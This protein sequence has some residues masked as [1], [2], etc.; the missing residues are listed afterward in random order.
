M[1]TT[2]NRAPL[3]TRVDGFTFSWGA[4]FAGVFTVLSIQVVLSL[5]GAAIGL[6]TV[7]PITQHSPLSGMTFFGA[8]WWVVSG[9]I[10]LSIGSFVAGHLPE[11]DFE[12]E[13]ETVGLVTWS[14]VN[15]I[16]V[17]VIL[18]TAG[19]VVAGGGRM[20]GGTFSTVMQAGAAVTPPIAEQLKQYLPEGTRDIN[21]SQIRSEL[22]MLIKGNSRADNGITDAF[23][24]T[25]NRNGGLDDPANREGTNYPLGS[26]TAARF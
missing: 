24:A 25:F 23:D 2:I 10:S 15:I 20:I 3:T 9:L 18:C 16:G 6:A 8:F 14:V 17:S 19:S 13:G 22:D 12:Y 5:L 11:A 1:E 7:D 21:T 26:F 4:I